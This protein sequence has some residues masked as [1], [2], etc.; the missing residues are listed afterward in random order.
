MRDGGEKRDERMRIADETR[1]PSSLLSL[2]FLALGLILACDPGTT[3]PDVLPFPDSRQI[4]VILDRADAITQLKNALAADSFPIARFDA[5]DAWLESP[6]IDRRTLRPVG[7]NG[8]GP[9]V[10]RLRAWAEP[11][12]P[13]N[14]YLIVELAW[15]GTAD[16]SLPPRMLE[17]SLPATDSLALRVGAVLGMIDGEFGFHAPGDTTSATPSGPATPKRSPGGVRRP[18]IGTP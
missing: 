13:G 4:E 2:P 11:A 5:R 10:V 7:D 3:R 9:D 17:R 14:S 1:V 15:R 18:P 16:P 6:W 12:R 8:L